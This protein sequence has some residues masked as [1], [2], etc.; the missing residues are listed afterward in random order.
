MKWKKRGLI[1]S[2]RNQAPWLDQYAWVPTIDPLGGGTFRVFFAGRNRDKLSQTG[3]FL[4]DGDKPNAPYEVSQTPVIPLGPLGSFDDSAVV[5]CCLVNHR[6]RK[7]LYYV[8]W[9]QGRRVPYYAA[10]GLAV[11]DD[12]G[13]TFQKVSKA[14]ILEKNDV[15][16][17]FTASAFVMVDEGVWRMWYTSNTRWREI[18]GETLPRYHIKYAESEDGISWDQSGEVAIDFQ[19]DDEFA[20]SRPWVIKESGLYRMWYSYRGAAYRIGYAESED[21]IQWRRLDE[22]AGIDVSAGGW[23]AEMI[24]YACVFDHGERRFMLYNGDEFGRDGIG[25]AERE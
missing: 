10:V 25:L 19:S 6:G 22:L 12:G 21:G 18:N 5:P 20:I 13:K 4:V 15:D 3:S 16:P 2:P 11:S 17:Y 24:E 8:G 1:F 23:D 9:M 14:P 7:Y